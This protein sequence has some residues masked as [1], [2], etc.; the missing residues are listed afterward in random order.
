MVQIHTTEMVDD[1]AK[2]VHLEDGL[3]IPAG[4]SHALERGGDHIMFMGLK[5]PFKADGEVPVTLVFEKAGEIELV[6]PVDLDR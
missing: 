1:V 4:E 5:A 6:I 3:V 2:M